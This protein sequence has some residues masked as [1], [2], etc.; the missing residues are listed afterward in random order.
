MEKFLVYLG[1]VTLLGIAMMVWPLIGTI[2]GA[3]SGWVVGWFFSETLLPF[4]AAFGLKDPVMWQ[5][6][7]G[8]G[9]IGGFFARIIKIEPK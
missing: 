2:S 5:I 9:F 7:M 1:A 6:G 3:F 8:L 4:F